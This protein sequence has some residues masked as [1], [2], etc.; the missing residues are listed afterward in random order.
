MFS[1]LSEEMDKNNEAWVEN[2]RVIE[3]LRQ[4]IRERIVT[5]DYVDDGNN[6]DSMETDQDK[7]AHSLYPVLREVHGEA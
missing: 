5:G 4:F 6:S 1:E 3:A 2:I 7:E